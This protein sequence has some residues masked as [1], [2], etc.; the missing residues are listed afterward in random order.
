[1]LGIG[2]KEWKKAKISGGTRSL[3]VDKLQYHAEKGRC[4]LHYH[5]GCF[6]R[7][8]FNGLYFEAPLQ[9]SCGAPLQYP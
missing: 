8:E 4:A 9:V 6:A 2:T 5:A 3:L 1:M 7:L